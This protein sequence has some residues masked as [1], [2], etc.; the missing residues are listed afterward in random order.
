[1]KF[2]DNLLRLVRAVPLIDGLPDLEWEHFKSAVKELFFTTLLSTSPL[3]IGAFAA[4]LISAGT[5]QSENIKILSL[6][7]DNLKASI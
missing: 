3:W 1:M 6:L 4:S 7:W 2:K 5:S